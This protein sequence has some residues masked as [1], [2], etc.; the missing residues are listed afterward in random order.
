MIT[1]T[2]AAQLPTDPGFQGFPY[3]QQSAAA[4]YRQLP[5]EMCGDQLGQACAQND[6]VNSVG[7]D[8]L[9]AGQIVK[10]RYLA[11][12][13][14]HVRITLRAANGDYIVS[15]DSLIHHGAWIKRFIINSF[16]NGRWQGNYQDVKGFPFTCPPVPTTITVQITVMSSEFV[17][18]VNDVTLSKYPFRGSLTPDKVVEVVCEVIDDKA[19]I[20]GKLEEITLSF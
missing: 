12:N 18:S 3:F 9:V 13:S 8:S 5:Q 14:G 7:V 17:I 2:A 15:A 4:Q 1:A 6:K 11:P 10:V 16:V 20:K 19:S